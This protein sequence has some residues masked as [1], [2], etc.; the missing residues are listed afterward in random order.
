[1]EDR[2]RASYSLSKRRALEL[3]F[4][5][6]WILAL[7]GYAL[8]VTSPHLLALCA[9]YKPCRR[10]RTEVSAGALRRACHGGLEVTRVV[11]CDVAELSHGYEGG[12]RRRPVLQVP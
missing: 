3:G 12:Y 11:R 9:K 7:I 10:F 1:M 4:Y 8:A 5:A 2:K 6:A